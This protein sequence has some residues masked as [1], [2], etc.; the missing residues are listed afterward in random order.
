MLKELPMKL[1]VDVAAESIALSSLCRGRRRAGLRGL[2]TGL[3]LGAMLTLSA[4]AASALDG[5]VLSG[6]AD[7]A[8][9]PAGGC[10]ELIRIK[11]P[12]L[13]CPDGQIG[14][15]PGDDT[16]E[17]S[18]RLPLQDP[19]LEGDGFFGPDLNMDRD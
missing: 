5:I 14:I 7:E 11:Y 15:A 4:G 8:E 2:C 13:S 6:R 19:F 17:N 10:P 3:A 18:R 16:W 1:A 12:F 9:T